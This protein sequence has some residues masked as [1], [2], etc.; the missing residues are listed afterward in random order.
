MGETLVSSH[1]SF[2]KNGTYCLYL[3]SVFGYID[4]H[5]SEHDSHNH[6]SNHHY[7][8]DHDD[9][10]DDDSDAPALITST[11]TT[12]NKEAFGAG[13]SGWGDGCST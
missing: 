2:S 9:D 4:E 1:H 7:D 3:F 5:R 8:D 13:G 12:M 11:A 6:D 10:G